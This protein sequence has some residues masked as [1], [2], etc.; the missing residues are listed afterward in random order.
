MVDLTRISILVCFHIIP[1]IS[2]FP[3]RFDNDDDDNNSGTRVEANTLRLDLGDGGDL[4]SNDPPEDYDSSAL[5]IIIGI[6]V[7]LFF[8]MTVVL[9]AVILKKVLSNTGPLQLSN[10]TPGSF[11]D[12]QEEEEN[13]L[14]LPYEEQSLYRQAKLFLHFNPPELATDLTLAQYLKIEEKGIGAWDFIPDPSMPP[15]IINVENRTELDFSFQSNT[16]KVNYPCSI[17]SNL[18]I[19]R[20]HE[21]YY[22]ESKIFELP[23]PEETQLSIGLSTKPYPFFRLPGRHQFS[24]AYDHDGS[25]RF[26]NSFEVS[27]KENNVFPKLEKGDVVGIGYRTRT[28]TIFFTRNGK[29]LSER[30]LGG[31]I[32]KLTCL[33]YPTVGATNDCKIHINIGQIGYVFIEAN[34]KK[35]GFAGIEGTLPP[36]PPYGQVH[37]DVLIE[38][39]SDVDET[40]ILS[41]D[42]EEFFSFNSSNTHHQQQKQQQQQQTP[43]TRAVSASYIEDRNLCDTS[44]RGS[45]PNFPP[46]FWA[47]SVSIVDNITLNTLEQELPPL[48]TSDNDLESENEYDNLSVYGNIVDTSE[49]VTREVIIDN[50]DIENENE[51]ENGATEQ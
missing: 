18:P 23:H 9:L 40:D 21:V 29:K 30:K 31:H 25:R 38:S 33:L 46:P 15:N 19:P 47:S 44:E 22:F 39:R 50:N 14:N 43:G 10:N 28:G 35:W 12:E 7:G 45:I 17:Q 51:N 36:P 32:K 16:F 20:T 6:F 13:L 37:D 26:N 42:N 3:A 8:T 5:L 11:A 27:E 49:D 4:I 2:A 34:V 24:I 48:Y 41:R 1:Q